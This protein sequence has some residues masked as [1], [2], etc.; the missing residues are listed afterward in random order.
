MAFLKISWS[1]AILTQRYD[2]DK[3]AAILKAI[4]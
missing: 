4:Y 3:I 1:N 2:K